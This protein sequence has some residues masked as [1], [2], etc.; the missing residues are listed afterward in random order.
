MEKVITHVEHYEFAGEM[1]A[2]DGVLVVVRS[3]TSRFS[4][5]LFGGRI[6]RLPHIIHFS[7]SAAT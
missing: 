7:S 4:G 1:V 6:T 5:G 3:G 2:G